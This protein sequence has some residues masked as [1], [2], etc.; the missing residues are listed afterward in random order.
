MWV[1]QTY[2]GSPDPE[3]K[4]FVYYLWEEYKGQRDVP[5]AIIEKLA[6][7]GRVFGKDVSLFAPASGTKH[8]IQSELRSQNYDFFWGEIGPNTPGL[9]L[10]ENILRSFDP[11]RDGYIFF[12]LPKRVSQNEKAMEQVFESLHETC[13]Q[14][15][16][17]IKASAEEP[18]VRQNDCLLST[19]YESAQLKVTFMGLGIDFKPI[20]SRFIRRRPQRA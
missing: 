1:A 4:L 15:L 20:I 14:K 16:G 10:T 3:A 5:K 11:K 17:S 19:V 13:I 8:E 12:P 2:L 18:R 7:A 6:G 9:L